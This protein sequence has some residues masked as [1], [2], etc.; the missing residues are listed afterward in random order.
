MMQTPIDARLFFGGL[1]LVT[2]LMLSGGLSILIG[3]SGYASWPNTL[4]IAAIP[5]IAVAVFMYTVLRRAAL[6][7]ADRMR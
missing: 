6:I 3:I 5:G 4:I 7:A 1:A 2:G